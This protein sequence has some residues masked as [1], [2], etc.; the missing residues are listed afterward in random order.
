MTRGEMRE[1]VSEEYDTPIPQIKKALI[2][3]P[4]S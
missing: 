2:K 1:M 4:Q 3:Q